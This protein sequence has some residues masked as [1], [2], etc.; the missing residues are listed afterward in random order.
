MYTAIILEPREHKALSFVLRNI[1]ENLDDTWNLQLYHGTANQSFVE[2]IIRDE[3][4]SYTSRI[5]IKNLGVEN[6]SLNEYSRLLCSAEFISKIPTEVFLIFQTDSMINPRYKDLIHTFLHYDYVGAPWKNGNVGNGG[7]SL[8]RRSKML[9]CI[10]R[11]VNNEEEDGFYSNTIHNLNKPPPELAALFSVETVYSKV[12]FAVHKPWGWLPLENINEITKNC[13]GFSELMELQD[14]YL[15]IDYESHAEE[16]RIILDNLKSL[17]IKS[18]ASLEGNSFYFHQTLQEF[19][20]LYTKQLNLFWCGKQATKRMC[21]IGFNA[22]HSTMLLLLG[23][24]T[25][26][27]FTIFDIGHHP[28]TKP[29]LEYIGSKYTNVRFEY[30]EGDSTK[31]MSKWIRDHKDYLESYDVVH[32]DGGHSELCIF[33]DMKNADILVKVGGI[34]IIDDTNIDYINK[35]VDLYVS[36]GNY[37]E[38]DMLKTVGYPHRILEKIT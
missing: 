4:S 11:G 35:Y 10:Q 14:N 20:E 16:R 15:Q 22:G 12:F 26:L 27:E 18:G 3:L 17:V 5:S 24:K 29:C 25:P 13:P 31:T 2:H 28:Y 1:L 36:S 23:R 30:I 37:R 33:N 7:F 8:R 19:P 6:L 38:I 21:E 34:L 32:V 9:E